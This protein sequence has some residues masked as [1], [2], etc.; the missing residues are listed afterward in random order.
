[1]EENKSPMRNTKKVEVRPASKVLKIALAA[2]IVCSTLALVALR[3]VHNG[4][5]DQTQN[6]KEE[7]A[8]IEQDNRELEE[9]FEDPD[10]I[11]NIQN[12]AKE[13]LGLVEPGTV[14]LEP[15]E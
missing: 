11:E 4:L 6:L 8:A 3:W 13:E 1:M 15:Q 14:I 7:A 12:I 9:R 2:L 10:S 5:L